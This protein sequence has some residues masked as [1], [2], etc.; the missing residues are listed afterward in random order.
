MDYGVF[1]NILQSHIKVIKTESI[2]LSVA[3]AVPFLL[4]NNF[5]LITSQP[6]NMVIIHGCISILWLL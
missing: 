6:E 4:L 2:K 5:F 3:R 1:A